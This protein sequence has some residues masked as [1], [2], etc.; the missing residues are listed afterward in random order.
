MTFFGA[1]VPGVQIK[2]YD[3]AG[4]KVRELAEELGEEQLD[5]DGTNDDG[6]PLASGVY[7]WVADIPGGNTEKGK[8]GIIR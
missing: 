5:W 1:G 7:I 2:I 6:K 8:V 3:K 4:S